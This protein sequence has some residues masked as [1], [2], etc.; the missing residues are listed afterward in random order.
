VSGWWRGNR[1]WVPALPLSL[2]AMAASSGYLLHDYWWV[3]E[4][5]HEIASADQG[6]YLRVTDAYSDYVGT[7]THTFEVR[8]ASVVE[9]DQVTLDS[10][11]GPGPTPAGDQALRV[12]LDWKADP[13]ESMRGCTV[14]LVDS[15]GRRY[16]K[17]DRN[18]EDQCVPFPRGGPAL[19]VVEGQDR[20]VPEGE[21]RPPT[22][23][24]SPEFLVP[25]GV[26]ITEVLVW[27]KLPHYVRLDVS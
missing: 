16:E 17:L 26:R 20:E 27:W 11:D 7:A 3:K 5:R 23:S 2:A 6:H 4:P 24:T 25:D 13:D 8:L 21:D 15:E 1:W 22:W 14:A 19:P 12:Y 9:T 18:I 10:F